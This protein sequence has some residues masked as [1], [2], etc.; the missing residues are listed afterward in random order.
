MYELWA[1]CVYYLL[2]SLSFSFSFSSPN[3]FKLGNENHGIH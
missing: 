2:E 3:L 1:H